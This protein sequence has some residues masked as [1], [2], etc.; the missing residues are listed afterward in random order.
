L[1]RDGLE[2]PRELEISDLFGGIRVRADCDGIERYALQ[3]KLVFIEYL[4]IAIGANRPPVFQPVR[5]DLAGACDGL[6]LR[7]SKLSNSRPTGSAVDSDPSIMLM[8]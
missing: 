6:G 4:D 1:A 3:K 5:H 7:S 8:K 2:L